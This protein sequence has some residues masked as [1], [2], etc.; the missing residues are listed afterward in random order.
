MCLKEMKRLTKGLFAIAC[1]AISAVSCYKDGPQ[2]G[3]DASIYGKWMLDTQT[4]ILEASVSGS[5]SDN[6][7]VVDFG[8]TGCY[9]ELGDEGA[10][11]YMGF[12]IDV[13]TFSYNAESKRID[14]P[15]GL[16]VSD[17]GKA[18]VLAGSYD[19]TELTDDR[20]VLKQEDFGVSIGSV[21]ATQTAIYE[22]HRKEDPAGREEKQN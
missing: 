21:K 4:I 16:S 12:K 1:I 3:G 9:L 11:A 20:L 13:S 8:G 18:F 22:F 19:V 6:K 17:N 14:F 15:R 7:T 2:N 10:A 5:G